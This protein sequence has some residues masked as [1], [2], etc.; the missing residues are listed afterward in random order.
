M[1]CCCSVRCT[2]CRPSSG[3]SVSAES[4][5]LASPSAATGGASEKPRTSKPV[6]AGP[7]AMPRRGSKSS[8]ASGGSVELAVTLSALQHGVIPPTLNYQTPD[9]TCPVN[10]TAE[11]TPTDRRA[12]LKL[13]YNQVGQAAANRRD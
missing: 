3:G 13:N 8:G 6:G 7:G 11:L 5:S 2:A 9:P 4:G 1:C 10:V 12:V